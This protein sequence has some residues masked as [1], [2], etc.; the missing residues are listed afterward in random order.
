MF[1]HL[2]H[3]REFILTIHYVHHAAKVF[4]AFCEYE[5]FF[6]R[7]SFSSLQFPQHFPYL[8]LF[9]LL[10]LLFVDIQWVKYLQYV[11]NIKGIRVCYVLYAFQWMKQCKY[12]LAKKHNFIHRN[13][14]PFLRQYEPMMADAYYWLVLV[15]DSIRFWKY[16]MYIVILWISKSVHFGLGSGSKQRLIFPNAWLTYSL[17]LLLLL[18]FPF[19]H[20][21]C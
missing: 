15:S 19:C 13:K 3:N 6:I 9:L 17:S 14:Q 5:F 21:C 11:R 8:L 12:A 1:Q 20:C 2:K 10:I 16:Y 7:F 18:L 4:S